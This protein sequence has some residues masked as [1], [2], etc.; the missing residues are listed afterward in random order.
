MRPSTKGARFPR[1]RDDLQVVEQVE[2][3]TTTFILKDPW[4][5]RFYRLRPLEYSVARSL[6]GRT[7]LAG[8]EQVLLEQ[9]LAVSQETLQQFVE[10]LRQL[11]LLEDTISPT[12]AARWD[13]VKAGTGWAGFRTSPT[14][15]KFPL[16]NP[17]PILEHLA[18]LATPLFTRAFVV[19]ALLAIGWV[20]FVL[21]MHWPQ[22]AQESPYLVTPAGIVMSILTSCLVI[23][24]HEFAHAI[25]CRKYGGKVS[26]IGFALYL[27]QPY[28]YTDVSD[29]WLL[30]R[31]QRLW[32]T[33][34]G[35]F[36]EAVLWAGAVLLWLHSVPQTDLHRAALTVVVSSAIKL[37]WNLNP[38][39]RLDGYYLLMDL[40]EIPNLRIKAQVF[41]SNLIRGVLRGRLDLPPGRD[42]FVFGAYGLLS[43]GFT[44]L[45]F[46][47]L[48]RRLWI[49]IQ[50]AYP[51]QYPWIFSLFLLVP[52]IA[53]VG[54]S[55]YA[56]WVRARVRQIARESARGGE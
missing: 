44:V 3:A 20:S 25:A 37:I 26:D 38:L 5:H 27:F 18:R 22:L 1:L 32:V 49:M 4:S 28:F 46:G 33:L 39:L 6:T 12:D 54:Q 11:G 35:P 56:R 50:W 40:L 41:W 55:I 14:F 10:R 47:W 34:A 15:V 16:A 43:G 8:V 9:G 2:G 17:G 42:T 52:T 31:T 36:I 53:G 45:L 21:A 30:P 48:V 29:A 24:G 19:V 7:G 51:A 13:S 23:T